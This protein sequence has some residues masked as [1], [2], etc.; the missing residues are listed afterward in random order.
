MPAVSG[1]LRNLING[2]SRQ[3]MAVRLPTQ[4]DEQINGF[5][6]PARGH[7]K[8]PPTFHVKALGSFPS[9][10][11]CHDINRDSNERYHVLLTNGDLKVFDK[12]GVEKTV[13]FPSGK[14]YLTAAD[15][16]SMFAAAT[17]ADHTFISNKNITCAMTAD[18]A[19]GATVSEALI[20]VRAVNYSKD[21]KILIDGNIVAWYRTGDGTT[22]EEEAAVSP[23]NV[24]KTLFWGDL[25]PNSGAQ[26]PK[27]GGGQYGTIYT[28]GSPI[29][30]WNIPGDGSAFADAGDNSEESTIKTRLIDNL[31]KA[32]WDIVRYSNVLHLKKKNGTSFSIRSEADRTASSDDNI[33]TIKNVIQDFSDLP[34][35]G[36][37]GFVVE[38]AGKPS[39]PSDNYW[40]KLSKPDND[41]NNDSVVWRECPKPGVKTTFNASTLPHILRRET[42]GTFTFT[43]AT[44][45]IRR[46]GDDVE[47][48]APSF[49]GGKVLDVFFHRGRLGFLRDESVIL[50]RPGLFF[51][52]WRLTMTTDVDDDPI[53]VAGTDDVVSI[54]QQAVTFDE[55][56][57]IVSDQAIHRLEGG[58]LLTQ[59]SVKLA[60]TAQE[61]IDVS[62]APVPTA[63]TIFYLAGT[64]N[65]E[66]QVNYSD[67]RE[68]YFQTDTDKDLTGSVSDHVPGYI[69]KDVRKLLSSPT[70]NLLLVLP[71]GTAGTVYCYQYYWGANEKLQSSWHHWELGS[72]VSILGGAV[73]GDEVHLVLQRSGTTVVERIPVK[74]FLAD[75]GKTWMIRL[76]RRVGSAALSKSYNAGT[77]RTTFTLPYDADANTLAVYGPSY[78]NHGIALEIVSFTGTSIV[79]SGN[80]TTTDI[81]FG[82][83]YDHYFR[84][85]E[86]FAR[87]SEQDGSV[88]LLSVRLQILRLFPQFTDAAHFK[89]DVTPRYRAQKRSKTYSPYTGV[90]AFSQGDI[91]LLRSGT[92]GVAVNAKSDLCSVEFS[93]PSHLPASFTGVE[94][95]GITVPRTK[96]IA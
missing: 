7:Q 94:W 75:P 6:T 83:L 47:A 50:T 88:P 53:D 32:Q 81:V 45:E 95:E 61:P 68:L 42:D 28:G 76:D 82:K 26:E 66:D 86:L 65:T 15:P 78:D 2:V 33:I 35:H 19:P 13:A 77:N 43:P 55:D 62:V 57:F 52:F 87:G 74:A 1:T 72:G 20:F 17:S 73:W 90:D 48:P 54:F 80:H 22:K 10:T 40:V 91:V 21:Y 84:L 96:R 31:P 5:S 70:N 25:V 69:P 67:V 38:V 12:T 3:P 59:T 79:L 9:S 85:N 93:N 11:F 24:A 29:N 16:V 23:V 44:W 63:R 56:L 18:V 4:L 41:D 14:A 92:M 60:L 49:I 34:N 39:D 71:S 64:A 37:V 89:V 58:D 8:R 30:G 36:P 46:C 27:T 51:D